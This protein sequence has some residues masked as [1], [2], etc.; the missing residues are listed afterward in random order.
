MEHLSTYYHNSYIYCRAVE[1]SRGKLFT[2]LLKVPFTTESIYSGDDEDEK[3][4][5]ESDVQ[6]KVHDEVE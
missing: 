6:Y 3:I 5:M 2:S 4:N 1:D